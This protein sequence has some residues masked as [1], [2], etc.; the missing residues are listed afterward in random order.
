MIKTIILL[1]GFLFFVS[2]GKSGGGSN[3]G[4]TGTDLS[5]SEISTDAPVPQAALNFEVRAETSGFN[6]TQQSKIDEAAD[7]IKKV[8]SS[9][10]FKNKVLNHTYK[11][12]KT[13]V[14][15]SGLSNAE[16]YKKIIEGSEKLSPSR[17]N[18]MDLDLETYYTSANVVGYTLPNVMRIW[19]NT[20]YLNSRPA[21]N[22]TTNM[23]HEWLHKLGFVHDQ[24]HNPSRP[25]SVPYAIGY[26]VRD[27]AKKM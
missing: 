22:V 4:Q 14:D 5:L 12:K 10:E 27:L 23:M 1:F 16:I 21:W 17:D 24:K 11:G 8:V 26:L 7:L 15:N 25:Y 19:M 9:E 13:Y 2:C 6:G 20:K 3:D 18:E